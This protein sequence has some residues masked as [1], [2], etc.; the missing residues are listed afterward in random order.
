MQIKTSGGSQPIEEV[1]TILAAIGRALSYAP[2]RRETNEYRRFT[3]QPATP[4][5]DEF[6]TQRSPACICDGCLDLSVHGLRPSTL[7]Q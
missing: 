2:E 4:S 7:S 1:F 3:E 5:P 6:P